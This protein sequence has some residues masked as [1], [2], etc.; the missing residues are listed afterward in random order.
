MVTKG[1][2]LGVG[3]NGMGIWDGNI[4]KLGCDD[5]WIHISIKFTE[6]KKKKTTGREGDR[7]LWERSTCGERLFS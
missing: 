2:R 3:R 7:S 5:G 1:D 4:V 6:K